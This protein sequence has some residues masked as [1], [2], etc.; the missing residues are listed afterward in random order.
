[1]LEQQCVQLLNQTLNSQQVAFNL[2]NVKTVIVKKSNQQEDH[3]QEDHH[4]QGQEDQEDHHH[5]HHHQED[6]EDHH[7]QDQDQQDQMD[8]LLNHQ[9]A[10]QILH[11]SLVD[12]QLEI[13]EDALLVISSDFNF[14]CENEIWKNPSIYTS[15]KIKF[16]II[17]F[18]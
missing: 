8:I 9:D 3:N 4:H 10:I 16:W 5:R 2:K 6:Q 1:M 11:Q 12:I 18:K 15:S 14:Y 17:T 13:L 7:H